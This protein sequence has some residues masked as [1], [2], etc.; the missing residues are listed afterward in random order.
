MFGKN[1]A[2]RKL[3]EMTDTVQA[4]GSTVPVPPDSFILHS[5]VG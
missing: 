4:A 2:G 1:G 5:T 3:F